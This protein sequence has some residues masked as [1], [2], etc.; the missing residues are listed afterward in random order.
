[1]SLSEVTIVIPCYNERDYILNLLEDLY[2]QHG[3]ESLE[4]IIADANSKDGTR[5]LIRAWSF[6]Q[7]RL[8]VSLI[9]GGPVSTGRNLGLKLVTTPYV[10]F[11][12]A[13][14]RLKNSGHLLDTLKNLKSGK[15]LVS[16]R[17]RSTSGIKSDSVYI[18]FNI[19]N[20]VLSMFKP[21]ALG[22]YFATTTDYIRSLG[23][24]DESIIHGEDWL[25]SSQYKP[26]DFKFSKYPIHV[27]DRRF[28]KMGYLR[29]FMLMVRSAIHGPS[30]MR[31][32]HGYW[33]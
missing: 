30:Y 6:D 24:W 12:D 23:G 14:V 31:K 9:D 33:D 4:V 5:E 10:I 11:I 18:A 22:S 17:P 20:R 15:L 27:D 32:D 21:F 29:M 19:F 3:S 25:L 28:R 13:D 16:S 8:Q 2:S 26:K 7:N 1:M